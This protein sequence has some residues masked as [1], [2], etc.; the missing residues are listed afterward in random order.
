MLEAVCWNISRLLSEAWTCLN[1][2]VVYSRETEE[3]KK[4]SEFVKMIFPVVDQAPSINYLECNFQAQLQLK[5]SMA[6]IF[7]DYFFFSNYSMRYSL[8]LAGPSLS[9]NAYWMLS[10]YVHLH[11]SLVSLWF[12]YPRYKVRT[13][14]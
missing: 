14:L 5:R 13:Y 3:K 11:F 12:G 7:I 6:I 2:P 8:F 1:V 4:R 9:F 10:G